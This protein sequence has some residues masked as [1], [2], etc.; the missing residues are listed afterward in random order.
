M[1]DKTNQRVRECNGA[2]VTRKVYDITH[3]K[4]GVITGFVKS[5][6]L[7]KTAQKVSYIDGV[8]VVLGVK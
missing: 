3:H 1:A 4:S 6:A 2:T 5:S 8:W 7:S